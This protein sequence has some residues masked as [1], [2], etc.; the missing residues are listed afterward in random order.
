MITR[1]I[2]A[3]ERR[4]AGKLYCP[5]CKPD[6]VDAVWRTFGWRDQA[7]DKHKFELAKWE[8]SGHLTEA[9]YQTWMRL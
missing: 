1:H 4:K 7:C 3:K 6:R 2:S 8:D 9:D 5:Y